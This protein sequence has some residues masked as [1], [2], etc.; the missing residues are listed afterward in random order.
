MLELTEIWPH[1]SVEAYY[2]FSFENMSSRIDSSV[3][4]LETN[5]VRIPLVYESFP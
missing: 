4:L 5:R 1:S 3:I 2:T